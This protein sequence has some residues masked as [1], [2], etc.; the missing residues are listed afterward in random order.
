LKEEGNKTGGRRMQK[1]KEKGRLHRYGPVG[2]TQ[3][4]TF[5]QC[6]GRLCTVQDKIHAENIITFHIKSNFFPP[7]TFAITTL[8]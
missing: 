6:M 4:G 5:F 3:S 2:S 8:V 1:N 7:H